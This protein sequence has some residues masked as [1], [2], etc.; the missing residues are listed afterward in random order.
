MNDGPL[1]M[2]MDPDGPVTAADVCL[3]TC[4]LSIVFLSVAITIEILSRTDTVLPFLI[5]VI[6]LCTITDRKQLV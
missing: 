4:R 1:D 6:M 5:I 3:P 2:R